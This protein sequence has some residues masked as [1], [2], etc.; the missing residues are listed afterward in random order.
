M[1]VQKPGVKYKPSLYYKME[2]QKSAALTEVRGLY[3][4]LK[5][6]R[7]KL[8]HRRQ[9]NRSLYSLLHW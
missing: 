1:Q 7:H 2:F 5:V 3:N 9:R 4:N 8:Y 6:F